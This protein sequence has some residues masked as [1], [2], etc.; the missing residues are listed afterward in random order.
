M[1][2][3]DCKE[4]SRYFDAFEEIM[5]NYSGKEAELIPLLQKLQGAYG[6]LPEDIIARLS[7]R[8]GIYVSKIMGVATFYSQFR[9]Q[10]VGEHVIRVC[11]GTA[12]HV[13]GAENVADALCQELGV[14]LGG[15]TEDGKFTVE[16]VACLG[17][18]SLSPV[19]MIDNE[20]HGRLTPDKVRTIMR[21]FRKKE[22][23]G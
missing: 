13:N 11:F 4:N 12:C 8:T 16:S 10:P 18:C 6:Y 22:A 1:C 21:E 15:T 5:Q 2:S 7:D 23:A 14:E 20:T 19:M 3:C 17:C 9:L